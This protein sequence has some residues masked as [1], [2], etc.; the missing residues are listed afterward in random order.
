[1]LDP[2]EIRTQNGQEFKRAGKLS[3]GEV[4]WIQVY[5]YQTGPVLEGPYFV[6]EITHKGRISEYLKLFSTHDSLEQRARIDKLWVPIIDTIKP[7]RG[8]N[9]G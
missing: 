4:C 9:A 2:N 3:I 6:I 7:P 8:H 5:D 1:M